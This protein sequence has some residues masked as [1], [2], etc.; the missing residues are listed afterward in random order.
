MPTLPITWELIV[1]LFAIL[2]S[3]LAVIYWVKI[4]RR[5]YVEQRRFSGWY[6]LFIAALAVLLFNL[7]G[8]VLIFSTSEIKMGG[9]DRVIKIN[10][11]TLGLIETI[12]RTIIAIALTVGAYLLYA[13]M[14]K[15]FKYRIMPIVPVTES[16]SNGEQIY[17]L[18]KS[19]SYLVVEEKPVKSN[20]VFLDMV[21][22]GA[23]GLYIT[24]THP[25][26]IR[27]LYGLQ[28]TPI[29]WLSTERSGKDIIEPRD[30]TQ[31]AHTIKDFISKTNNGVVMLD[32]LEY[33]IT[34]NTFDDV[35]KFVQSLDDAISE[36]KS[37][38]IM[39]IDPSAMDEKQFHLLEREMT[40][41]N[42]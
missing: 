33:L 39:P 2:V 14:K 17:K 28:K 27:G 26:R 22:H 38:L 11:A 7:A 41:F 23:E 8:M 25:K 13:P 18:R 31:L 20:E 40:E 15:G 10:A 29:I 35:I 19:L 30:L 9:L 1:S 21:T 16:P 32:G 36:S 12:S 6:W 3:L 5:I 24:R 42:G 34:Q 37:R 4:Y